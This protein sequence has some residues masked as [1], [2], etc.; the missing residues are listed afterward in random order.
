MRRYLFSPIGI[1]DPIRDFHDGALLHIIRNFKPDYVCMYMTKEMIDIEKNDIKTKGQSR[2][3]FCLDKIQE[4]IKKTFE[5]ERI[6]DD[7]MEDPSDMDAF[8][9]IFINKIIE[10]E[11]KAK[12]ESAN[13]YEIL[14]NISSG[15]SAQKAT[16]QV[17][18]THGN[19]KIMAIQVKTPH[20]KSNPRNDNEKDS[21][22]QD[23]WD[24]NEDNVRDFENRCSI[25][26]A[27]KFIKISTEK[28]IIKG[29]IRNYD[30]S[31]V[32]DI[33]KS[34]GATEEFKNLVK[35]AK[36]RLDMNIDEVK[37]ICEQVPI[38]KADKF[39]VDRPENERKSIEYILSLKIKA[40]KDLSVDFIRGLTPIIFDLFERYYLSCSG[41]EIEKISKMVTNGGRQIRK[42]YREMIEQYDKE[43]LEFLDKEYKDRGGFNKMSDMNSDV[44]LQLMKYKNRV[45]KENIELAQKLRDVEKSV[46]NL[47]AHEIEFVNQKKLREMTSKIT[48]TG[49][50]MQDILNLIIQ[51]ANNCCQFNIEERIKDSY[52]S[53]NDY[54]ISKIDVEF[55]KIKS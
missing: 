6:D 1:T 32:Y 26:E 18:A 44:Y 40:D 49:Y 25:S 36:C 10:I 39:L 29:L 33:I 27:K 8:Y 45:P 21:S 34:R 41:D 47:V 30:Y 48:N 13:E 4:V 42:V 20:K 24:T 31:S 12:R 38:F 22:L 11:Y 50:N 46:R 17:I 28:E 23:I 5:I 14:L 54:I 16:L 53:M 15:T 3:L 7:K 55:S 2:Y 43:L 35:L 51:F 37:S 19:N 52:K 9:Q